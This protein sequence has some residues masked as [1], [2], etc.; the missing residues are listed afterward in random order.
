MV[1]NYER[2]LSGDLDYARDDVKAMADVSHEGGAI[3]KLI[4]ETCMLNPD[5]IKQVCHLADEAGADFVKTSTGLGAYGARAE[6]L[7]IMREH[8]SK[9]VKMSGAMDPADIRELLRAASGRTDGLI[10]FD[11]YMVRIGE[12]TLSEYIK[13]DPAGIQ[14]GQGTFINRIE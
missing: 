10:D 9:G 12:G 7:K 4:I 13:P 1:L 5:Q 11:P 2:F 6:D 8:F 3:L 14:P